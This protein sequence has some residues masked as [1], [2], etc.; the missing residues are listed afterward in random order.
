MEAAV[1]LRTQQQDARLRKISEY[2]KC[3]DNLFYFAETYVKLAQSGTEVIPK[4]YEPQKAFLNT[5]CNYHYAVLLKT[6]QTG[7]SVAS[8][9][10][11]A[12]AMTFFKNIVIGIVSR[13]GDEATD[14]SK[15]VMNI[16][17][18]L[19]GWMRP[20]FQKQTEQ[21][22]RL[23]NGSELFAEAVSASNPG[24][25]FRGK[26]I[27]IAVIDEAAYIPNV[28]VAYTAFAP[29][30]FK[31]H[32]VAREQ[33]VPFALM[34]ISTPNRTVGLG[35]W[36]AEM[37][38]DANTPGSIF[39]AHTLYWKDISDF[40]ND[41]TWYSTQCKILKND[42]GKIKQ[43]LEME[44]LGSTDSWLPLTTIDE[45]NRCTRPPL[46]I[47]NF[48][49]GELWQWEPLDINRFYLIGV[50]TASAG[51]GDKSTIEV[52]DF[53]EFNQVAEFRG[54]LE[55]FD[56]C[57]VMHT[58]NKLYPN[59]QFVVENN[60]YGNQ[61]VETLSRSPEKF[62]LYVG[63]DARIKKKIFHPNRKLPY[64]LNTNSKTRPLI[65]DALYTY[66][67]ERPDRVKSKLLALELMALVNK[68]GASSS[69]VEAD[70]G[71]NDDLCL[72]TGFISYVRMYDPP[73]GMSPHIKT[74]MVDDIIDTV[75]YNDDVIVQR[76][77]RP[78]I[79]RNQVSQFS[80]FDSVD[81]LN[82]ELGRH[83]KERVL[84]PQQSG[85]V[86]VFEVLGF[87]KL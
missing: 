8:Q 26:S 22:F 74:N 53:E 67:V 63:K 87:N 3:R 41:P 42:Q 84:N 62:N 51:G 39:K 30:L 86:N 52:W 28:D 77:D 69:R 44:F 17:H 83:L 21:S 12:W 5:L 61:V 45:L 35:Q 82:A 72:A 1:D 24:G 47:I 33:G 75:A 79:T 71:S 76:G 37:W 54:K 57:S 23:D 66:I 32:K 20:N 59:N 50:D 40:A 49:G 10:Y 18:A 19:P 73:L 38:T 11:C 85:N 29:A 81:G 60:S 48:Q 70:V 27:T 55:V 78:V 43:E 7:G 6:R 34:I 4:L 68:A 58:V 16:I 25:C 31:A 36:Y 56:F 65:M 15:K 9:I 14:F 46:S 13:K 64:G 80:N 2:K